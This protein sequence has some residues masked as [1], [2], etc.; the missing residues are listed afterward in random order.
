MEELEI[1]VR[2]CLKDELDIIRRDFPHVLPELSDEA[3]AII[4]KYTDEDDAF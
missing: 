3:K 4:Y 2:T 1:Y